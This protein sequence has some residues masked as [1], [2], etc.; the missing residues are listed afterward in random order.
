[1]PKKKQY[2]QKHLTTTQRIWIEKGLNDGLSFAAIARRIEKHPSTVA[3]E[4]KK[5]RTFQPRDDSPS[6]KPLKCV[7]YKNCTDCG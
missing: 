1:M 2:N 4:V 5:Y 3:K 6:N 7:F